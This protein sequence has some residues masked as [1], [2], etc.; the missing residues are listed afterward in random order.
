MDV[1]LIFLKYTIEDKKNDRYYILASTDIMHTLQDAGFII[2]CDEFNLV[3]YAFTDKKDLKDRFMEIRDKNI[4]YIKKVFMTRDEYMDL[5]YFYRDGR[6]RERMLLSGLENDG[7]EETAVAMTD[8]EFMITTTE[9]L[10]EIYYTTMG[11]YTLMDILPTFSG[12]SIFSDE[13][14][15]ALDSIGVSR[16]LHASPDDSTDP[17]LNEL[18]MFLTQFYHTLRKD[19]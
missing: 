15:E 17:S 7:V 9:D 19:L 10:D 18:N 2:P 6:I 1:Y 16:F 3:L 5:K 14:K 8:H 4:F 11:E 12:T 13:V